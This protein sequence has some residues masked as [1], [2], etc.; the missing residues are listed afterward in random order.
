VAIFPII[1]F[2]MTEPVSSPS[3]GSRRRPEFFWSWV[4]FNILNWMSALFALWPYVYLILFAVIVNYG[5]LL[6]LIITPTEQQESY[7]LFYQAAR[8]VEISAAILDAIPFLSDESSRL[9][10]DAHAHHLIHCSCF[11]HRLALL[12]SDTFVAL[13]TRWLFSCA[14]NMEYRTLKCVDHRRFGGGAMRI[15]DH[16]R[17]YSTILLTRSARNRCSRT[18]HRTNRRFV[19]GSTQ[20]ND[21]RS[22]ISCYL[23]NEITPCLFLRQN[24]IRKRKKTQLCPNLS[25]IMA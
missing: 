17:R 24:G 2:S 12:E 19:H 10:P 15:C 5:I 21:S 18:L 4:T 14:T 3:A 8:R 6:G 13:L 25:R 22:L 20:K 7:E 1:F 11:R 16:C 9:A 23:M